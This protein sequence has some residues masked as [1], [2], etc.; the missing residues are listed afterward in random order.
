MGNREDLL[1]GARRC[2]LSKGYTRTTARDIATESG[3]SLA[4]I[5]YHFGSKDELLR[6]ALR[7]AI[8]GWG[9]EIAGILAAETE[10]GLSGAA[11]FEATW[12]RILASFARTRP[13]W[14][15]QFEVIAQIE[16]TPELRAAFPD[17]NRE[18]RLGLAELFGAGPAALGE[19]RAEVVGACYQA[20]LAG[21]AAQALVDP[22]GVPA[23]SDLADAV[24]A[25]AAAIQ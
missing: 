23:A 16:R 7:Q 24:R 22:D 3:V 17:A 2:L 14:A 13:L 19:R 25:I 10:P 5:G 20:L 1:D 4:A 18:A 9:E 6:A 12:Q 8:E 21:F 11:R 15:I